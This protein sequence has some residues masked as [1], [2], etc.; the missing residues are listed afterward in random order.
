MRKDD[1]HEEDL[2]PD[3]VDGEKVDRGELRNVIIE[4]CSPRLR[5]RFGTS[6]HVFGNGSLG[7]LDAQLHQF[8]VNPRCTPKSDSR[9]SWF[10]SNREF[11]SAFEDVRPFRG[12]LSKSRTNGILDDARRWR[13][14]VWPWS[15][16]NA[17]PTTTVTTKPTGIGRM[18]W[19]RASWVFEFVAARSIDGATRWSRPAWQLGHESPW[20]ETWA[21]LI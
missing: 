3:G 5:R 1:K 9:G 21:S 11:V 19:G 10:G 4:E 14:Q 20:E 15:R 2:K 8:A 12:G 7:N 18:V 6:N 16:L 13:F 17:I